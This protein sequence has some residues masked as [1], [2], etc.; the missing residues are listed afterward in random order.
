MRRRAV[1]APGVQAPFLCTTTLRRVGQR[2][3]EKL[4]Y[5]KSDQARDPVIDSIEFRAPWG[6]PVQGGVC[7]R[8][9]NLSRKSYTAGSR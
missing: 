6:K 4:E 9:L 8:H 2:G 1:V 5:G 7:K 3:P